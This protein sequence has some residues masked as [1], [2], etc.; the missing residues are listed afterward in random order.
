MRKSLL[1]RGTHIVSYSVY[2]KNGL[3]DQVLYEDENHYLLN[4]LKLYTNNIY[5][6]MQVATLDKEQQDIQ[7]IFRCK[8]REATLNALRVNLQ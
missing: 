7:F 8:D 4:V 6:G 1:F 2:C 3:K 5:F